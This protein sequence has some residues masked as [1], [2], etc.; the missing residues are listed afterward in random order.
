MEYLD[1]LDIK[2]NRTGNTK[3]KEEVHRNGDWHAAAHVWI[4]NSKDELLIQKKSQFKTTNQGKWDISA[5]GHLSAGEEPLEAAIRETKEELGITVGKEE[6]KHVLTYKR[7]V[8]HNNG[9]FINNGFQYVFLVKKDLNL[10]KIRF[11]KKEISEI[12]FITLSNLMIEI[13]TRNPQY[14]NHPEE[15]KTLAKKLNINT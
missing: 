8:T 12:K 4:I 9:T 5:A 2:G 11:N 14:I 15:F 1:I 13:N 10:S 3:S 7:Q 6:L